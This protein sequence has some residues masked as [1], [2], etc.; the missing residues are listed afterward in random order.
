MSFRLSTGLR[1]KILD[2]GG[3]GG[4]KLAFASCFINIYTGSQPASPDNPATGTLLGTV[5]VN[6]SGTGMTFDAS[7]AGVLSKAAAETWRFTGLTDG[8]AGWFRLWQTGD[9]VTNS[10]TTA[11]RLDGTCG[12]SGAE[13]NLTNLNI[14]N[15]QVNTCDSLTITQPAQ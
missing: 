5:S 6:G 13:L 2:G 8:V 10:S 9:T 1:G 11:A 12:T 15:G 7:V 14:T 3:S 4:Y